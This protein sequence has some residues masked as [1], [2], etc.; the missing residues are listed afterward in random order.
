MDL[1][2]FYAKQFTRQQEQDLPLSGVRIIDMASLIAAP[3]AATLLGDYGAEVIKV[4]NPMVPDGIRNWAAGE[5]M[6]VQP[7]WAVFARNKFPM[8]LNLKSREGTDLFF[9]LIAKAD[10]LTQ[11]MRP[12]ALDKLG[13]G[14]DMLLEINP[15]LIIGSVSGY[16]Q[17]GP[18]ASRPGFGT[19]AEAY[20][21]FTY[22]NAHPDGPPTSPP[23]ALA[24]LIA[25][26]HLALAIMIAL[27]QQKR[28][29][30]GGQE[31]DISLYEPL[32]GMLGPDF[33][34]YSLTG[35]IPRPQG[36]ELSYVAPRNSYQTKEGRWVSLSGSAQKAYERIMEAAGHPEMNE[37]PRF[38]TN[39][40]R[41]KE[42]N[43]KVVNQVIA[44]WIGSMTLDEV[45]KQCD[46]LGI[47]IG[48]INTMADIA[49]DPHYQARGSFV[50][51]EDPVSG[52][53][54]RIPNVAFRLLQT[55]GRIHFPGM[56][57]GSANRTI[58][59]QLLG[60][61]AHE[62]AALEKQGAL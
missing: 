60:R 12:G 44:E 46:N 11:N 33:L 3:F 40:E 22:L 13:I 42:E 16:G 5:G 61:Q 58:L 18:Y 49:E 48:T 45:I 38:S 27:R 24:D 32:F 31:I 30:K 21:G 2:A 35:K 52:E 14:K 20:S 47:T 28:G 56:P 39:E 23:L 59:Q 37:D 55:P 36:N 9:E 1:N 43:R 34:S 53:T 50:E 4:E 29:E 8:T 51:I 26:T 54:L 7:F 19:L 41:I 10:I 6:P 25:G 57:A 17:S 15:G 62:I